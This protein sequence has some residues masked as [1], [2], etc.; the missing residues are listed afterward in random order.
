MKLLP[1]ATV[2]V[3][4]VVQTVIFCLRQEWASALIFGGY[5]IANVGMAFLT[6]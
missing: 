6:R 3:C 4:Y 5:A 2:T 1:L